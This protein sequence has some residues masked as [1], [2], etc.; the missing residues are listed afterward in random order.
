MK[1]NEKI[2]LLC[3]YPISQI[4]NLR[5]N[6]P[7]IITD[8][9]TIRLIRDEHKSA[10][11]F[12]DGEIELMLGYSIAFQEKSRPLAEKLREVAISQN[13][14]L[15]VCIPDVFYSKKVLIKKYKKQDA[16]WWA[17]SNRYLAGYWKKFFKNKEYGNAF[18]SM[19]YMLYRE[20][21]DIANY[22]N[23]LKSIWKNRR[24]VLVEGSETKLGEGNDLFD[25]AESVCR[26]ICPS[27]NAFSEYDHIYKEVLSKTDKEDLI[28]ISLGPT[29]TVLA[30]D[31]AK[32]NRQALDLG[33]FDIEYMWYKMGATE[34]VKINGKAV[35]EAK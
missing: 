8:Y 22:V 28:I 13:D 15:I 14:D 7:Q 26:I 2:N 34:K 20:R 32:S 1:L 16:I 11:R 4:Y 27:Q 17:K 10:A 19:F 18:I 12:G 6:F 25:N 30:S 31:L 24:I 5:A 33:H 3:R 29:A 35:N 21:T 9:E 23:E